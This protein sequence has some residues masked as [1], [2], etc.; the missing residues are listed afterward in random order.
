MT[1]LL[2]S[3]SDISTI[4]DVQPIE[5]VDIT[6]ANLFFL[7]VLLGFDFFAGGGEE[8]E[9]EEIDSRRGCDISGEGDSLTSILLVDLLGWK[10]T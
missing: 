10:W 7:S 1:S 4:L 3:L 5:D 6:H 8:E 9:E 2:G